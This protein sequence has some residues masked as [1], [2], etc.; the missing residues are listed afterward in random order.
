MILDEVSEF[1]LGNNIK[2]KI[3]FTSVKVIFLYKKAINIVFHFFL[4]PISFIIY[5]KNAVKKGDVGKWYI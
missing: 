3:T 1:V 2:E 4:F 5:S